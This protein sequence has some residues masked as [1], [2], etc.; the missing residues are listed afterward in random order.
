MTCYMGP[1]RHY[2]GFHVQ[3]WQACPQPAHTMLGSM[4]GLF[5][6]T[7]DAVDHAF[8]KYEVT[9]DMFK[10][11]RFYDTIT[12][13]INSLTAGDSR[14]D[15]AF[16]IT[17]VPN[18][19]WLPY[20]SG[21]TVVDQTTVTGGTQYGSPWI[22]SGT[23]TQYSAITG[24]SWSELFTHTFDIQ[25]GSI[26]DHIEVQISNK[27][28]FSFPYSYGHHHPYNS[29]IAHYDWPSTFTTELINGDDFLGPA[30]DKL[31]INMDVIY[32]PN[33]R[34]VLV[35]IHDGFIM[36]TPDS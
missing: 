28:T 9:I 15:A 25:D 14:I 29:E 21:P 27:V 11:G 4:Y 34:G 30:Y 20:V 17:Y 35:Q 18:P 33:D 10:N 7:R 36:V 12:L 5:V 6:G 24:T 1:Q 23:P 13:P 32:G 8:T 2:T 16:G 3:P 19:Q 31:E 22:Y 26:G